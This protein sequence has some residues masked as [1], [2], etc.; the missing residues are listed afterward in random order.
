MNGNT[1]FRDLTIIPF[2]KDKNMVIACDSSAGIGEKEA[3][4]VRVDPAITAAFCLRVPLLELYCFGAQPICI[5]DL[6][7]NEYQ[8]TGAKMITG[9]KAEMARAGLADLPLNGSTEENMTTLTS[10]VGIT[11]IGESEGGKPLPHIAETCDLLQLGT[12][13]VGNEVVA[14]LDSIFSYDLV[15]RLRQEEG[16]LDMLPVGSKGI[17]YEAD[18]MMSAGYAIDFLTEEDLEKSGGPATVILLAVTK[19]VS[20]QLLN[21]YPELRKIAEIKKDVD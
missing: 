7:G 10:S 18:Q 15:R 2:S 1:A 9:I 11:V 5:V 17:R 8:P 19:A 14:H 6:I 21:S 12:P 20:Q 3:D 16:I 4:A 13:Y